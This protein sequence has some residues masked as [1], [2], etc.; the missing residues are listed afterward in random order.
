MNEVYR[1]GYK[2]IENDANDK[3]VGFKAEVEIEIVG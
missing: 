2:Y 3:A 1:G